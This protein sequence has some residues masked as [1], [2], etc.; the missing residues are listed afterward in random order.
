VVTHDPEIGGRARRRLEMRD[1][2]IE[3]DSA[4]E[5]PGA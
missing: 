4:T 2:Q 3:T 1:G 5:S